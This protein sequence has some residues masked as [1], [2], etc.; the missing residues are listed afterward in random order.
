M[1]VLLWRPRDVTFFTHSVCLL[2]QNEGEIVRKQRQRTTWGTGMNPTGH[3]VHMIEERGEM[4][5]RFI[6]NNRDPYKEEIKI[7]L[8]IHIKEKILII[9]PT[10]RIHIFSVLQNDNEVNVFIL[11]KENMVDLHVYKS[12]HT[13]TKIIHTKEKT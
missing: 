7:L 11:N 8:H 13:Y 10:Q 2:G 9:F 3:Y 1:V 6:Q 4:E 12:I 5:S